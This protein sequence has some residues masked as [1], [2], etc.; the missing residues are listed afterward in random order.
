MRFISTRV[1]GILDYLMG[2][3]LIASPWLFDFDNGG[4]ETWVEHEMYALG[5][6]AGAPPD[7][8]A[9]QGQ[10]WGLPP[11][12]PQRLRAVRYQPFI[13]TL[14]AN[15]RHCGALRLDHVMALMRL[16]WTGPDGGTYVEYPLDDLMGVLA[17]ESQR[18]RCMVIGEDLGNVAPRMREAMREGSLLSY[19][20]LLFEREEDGAFRPPAQWQPK[21]LAVVSTHDLP[22]LRGF[23]LGVVIELSAKL[24]LYP[25]PAAHE[26]VEHL[27]EHVGRDAHPRV[28]DVDRVG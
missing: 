13:D 19:K 18:H 4:A 16:F 25:D 24:E 10:D 26:H 17:L 12:S 7:P 2:P 27:G 15:M 28:R 6:H 1:H 21:A 14:R 20:P 9:P 11:W 8:L 5:M 22:T 3:L 23:W